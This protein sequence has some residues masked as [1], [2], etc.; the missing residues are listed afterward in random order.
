LIDSSTGTHLWADH[1]DGEIEDIFALQDRVTASVVSAI[2]PKLEQAEIE[3]AKRKPTESMDAY[4]Y[5]LRG[6]ASYHR[7]TK[8]GNEEALPLFYR[9][10]ELDPNFASPYG[11]AARCYVQRKALGALTLRKGEMAEVER[12]GKQAG[13]LGKDDAVALWTGGFT[14]AYVVGDLD[15]GNSFIDRALALNPNLTLAWTVSGWVKIWLAEPEL[16][17]ERESYAIKLS[18]H[19]TSL[20]SMQAATAL[21]HFCAGRYSEALSW[22]E[23]SMREQPN[24]VNTFGIIA[25]SAALMGN[26]AKAR[27][28]LLQLHRIH[29]TFRISSL[30]DHF[31][32]RRPEDLAR[33]KDG[34]RKAGSQNE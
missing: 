28:A 30:D 33:W 22:A 15:T 34:L 10:I 29:P 14:L 2:A 8:T 18:P 24:M 27:E 16:A 13:A 20:F 17:I 32:F 23:A 31:P 5:F 25:A 6:M 19:D 1:F 4:D 12:L 21:A 26:F 7:W 11:M 3:R 9:A